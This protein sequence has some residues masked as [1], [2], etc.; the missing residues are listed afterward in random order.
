MP[1]NGQDPDAVRHN[2]VSP[3]TNDLK[4]GLLQRRDCRALTHAGNLWHLKLLLRLAES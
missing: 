1:R 2:D 4:P 3:L